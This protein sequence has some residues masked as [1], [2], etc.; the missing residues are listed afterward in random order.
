MGV[1]EPRI[2]H[3]FAFAARPPSMA[4]STLGI[5][6]AEARWSSSSWKR[7]AQRHSPSS[8]VLAKLKMNRVD[9]KR[10]G[11]PRRKASKGSSVAQAEMGRR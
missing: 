1:E 5:D 8:T 4:W 2:R 3:P 9:G 6:S 7:Q 10:D 11:V